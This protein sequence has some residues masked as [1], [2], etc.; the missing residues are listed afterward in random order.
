LTH[1]ESINAVSYIKQNI[2]GGQTRILVSNNS[3]SESSVMTVLED[4]TP[5]SGWRQLRVHG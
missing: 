3:V 2:G 4:K 5:T 1:D